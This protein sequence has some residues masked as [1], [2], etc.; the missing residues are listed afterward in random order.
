MARSNGQAPDS[1]S[2]SAPTNAPPHTSPS[3]D[4]GSQQK[5]G[6]PDEI[7]FFNFAKQYLGLLASLAAIPLITNGLGVIPTPGGIAFKDLSAGASLLSI[8][9]FGAIFSLR[10]LLGRTQASE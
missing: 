7:E 1:K 9:A 3:A 8:I 2:A 10:Q 4:G 5:T 6:G